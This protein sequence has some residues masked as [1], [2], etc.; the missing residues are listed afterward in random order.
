MPVIKLHPKTVKE[1][2]NLLTTSTELHWGFNLPLAARKQT[3]S[4]QRQG[5]ENKQRTLFIQLYC[6]EMDI[7]D[8]SHSVVSGGTISHATQQSHQD[9]IAARSS[10]SVLYLRSLSLDATKYFFY[11]THGTAVQASESF[12]TLLHRATIKAWMGFKLPKDVCR[13]GTYAFY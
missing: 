5:W 1:L 7:G 11:N 2:L 9:K 8:T 3:H 12:F 4:I 10:E 13:H 6:W